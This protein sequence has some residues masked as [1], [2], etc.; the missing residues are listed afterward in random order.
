MN[1]SEKYLKGIKPQT[2]SGVNVLTNAPS[3]YAS[4][5]RMYMAERNRLFAQKRA[6]LPTDYVNAD[7]Q[8]LTKNFYDYTNLNIRLAD[9]VNESPTSKKKDDFKNILFP[10]MAIDYFPIGAKVI[11]MGNTWIA[12]NPSNMS[13]AN[14]GGIIAR[15]NASYNSYDY[16]GNIVTEPIVVEKYS[17]LGNNN[18]DP[19]NLV[20]MDG[21][22]NVTCQ[23]NS[24]TEKLGQNKRIIL[25]SK[26][27]HITG[28]ADFIQEFSGNRNS[29]HIIH[30]TARIDEP[31]E[32]E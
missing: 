5:Q 29:V 15:C 31:T 24:V 1:D 20:L 16:Y 11:T 26:P 14:S 6:Y 12:T 9:I 17:M 30:F 4:K 7:V 22:F 32:N 8:G 23:K 25:G 13:D 3:Q 21:Y 19:R 10:D 27:Y 18:E 28:F 2:L